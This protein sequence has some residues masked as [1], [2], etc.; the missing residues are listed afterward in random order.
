MLSWSIWLGLNSGM[1]DRIHSHDA[2]GE[3]A[4]CL[5]NSLETEL[6]G[7]REESAEEERKEGVFH[8]N[9]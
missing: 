5:R 3:D 8:L 9:A 1:S 2:I 4:L 7:D 6:A